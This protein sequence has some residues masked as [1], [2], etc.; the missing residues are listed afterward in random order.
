MATTE[1]ERRC[2]T[3]LPDGW[4]PPKKDKTARGWTYWVPGYVGDLK[5]GDYVIVESPRDDAGKLVEQSDRALVAEVTDANPSADIRRRA[6]KWI[7]GKVDW[8]PYRALSAL[9]PFIE[10]ED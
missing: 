7:V 1:P 10:G 6:R 8:E 9:A 3:V 2:V 4:E 5:N